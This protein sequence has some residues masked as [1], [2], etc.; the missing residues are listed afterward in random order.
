MREIV[1][2]IVGTQRGVGFYGRSKQGSQFLSFEDEEE[3]IIRRREGRPSDGKSMHVKAKML[4]LGDY[5]SLN[6]S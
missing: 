4:I 1:F 3:L 5:Q 6:M 2:D